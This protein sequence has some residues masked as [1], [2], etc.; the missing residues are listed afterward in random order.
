MTSAPTDGSPHGHRDHHGGRGSRPARMTLRGVFS[1]AGRN[2]ASGASRA[3]LFAMTLTLL[4]AL[5]C[6]ADLTVMRS[7]SQQVEQYV[8]SG[9]STYVLSAPGHVNGAACDALSG[10]GGVQ[11]AGALRLT[12]RKVTFSVLPS[13]GVP[14]TEISK[15]AETVFLSGASFTIRAAPVDD[16]AVTDRAADDGAV[17]LSRE[18]A[19]SMGVSR[20]SQTALLGGGSVRVNGVFDYPD[21]GRQSGFSYSVLAIVPSSGSFDQCWVRTWPVPDDIESLMMT[22][23]SGDIAPDS[24]QQ[25]SV[26]QLNATMG[27]SLDSRGMFSSRITRF[28]PFVML[29][30]GLALGLVAST[31]R[32]LELASALH[33]GVPKSALVSQ[34]LVEAAAWACCALILCGCVLTIAVPMMFPAADRMA[35]WVAMLRSGIAAAFGVTLGVG[36]GT[37]MIRERQLF[38]FFKSR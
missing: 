35:V 8:R 1:E 28:M 25:P 15:G 5:A 30:V 19:Q 17:L 34:M 6:A 4:L 27:A 10:T 32:R 31:S 16:G 14:L 3:A 13:T 33:C 12:D 2:L 18:A 7:L 37:A 23:V 11:A 9:G 29:A 22:V 26:S 24:Q 20:G 36:A 21:D 38:A